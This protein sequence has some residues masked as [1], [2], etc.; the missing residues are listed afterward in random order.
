MPK[1]CRPMT[2][3]W[4]AV[5][6]QNRLQLEFARLHAGE[7]ARK[8]F[9]PQHIWLGK[10]TPSSPTLSPAMPGKRPGPAT[11]PPWPLNRR[12]ERNRSWRNTPSA[13]A[14]TLISPEGR[15]R[16]PNGNE[17]T[18][19]SVPSSASGN[20]ASARTT[21]LFCVRPRSIS[22]RIGSAITSFRWPN[23]TSNATTF[24]PSWNA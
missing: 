10:L 12:N 24:A 7:I 14:R 5:V 20:N 21:V 1:S 18:R 22:L 11:V 3:P 2:C 17:R 6:Q 19:S 9:P 4:A 8:F 13:S 16:S 23:T 15:T